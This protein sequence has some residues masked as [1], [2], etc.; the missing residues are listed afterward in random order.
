MEHFLVTKDRIEYVT[1][2][3]AG[4]AIDFGDLSQQE[5]MCKW[6]LHLLHQLVDLWGRRSPAG[7]TVNVIDYI[8]IST[9]GNAL[10]FGDLILR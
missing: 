5:M 6:D 2:A 10:D 4:D 8:E 3:S 1:M 7:A 9:I